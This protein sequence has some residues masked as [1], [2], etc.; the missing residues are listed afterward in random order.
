VVIALILLLILY[1]LQKSNTTRPLINEVSLVEQSEE[2]IKKPTSE[3]PKETTKITEVNSDSIAEVKTREVEDLNVTYL[4]AYREFE[5]F[6]KCSMVYN[7]MKNGVDLTSNYIQ[8]YVKPNET[9]IQY[10]QIYIDLCKSLLL[11][12]KENS[13][14]ART[15]LSKRIDDTTPV[16][17]EEVALSQALEIQD[18][19]TDV[20]MK[21]YNEKSGNNQLTEEQ[22]AANLS[23]TMALAKELMI[24]LNRS[25]SEL[26]DA[27]RLLILKLVNEQKEL[28]N[29]SNISYISYLL[30]FF[31][32]FV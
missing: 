8:S 13:I 32:T 7:G 10:Y 4:T 20:S 6:N 12:E 29:S 16:T 24:I 25:P 23:R 30:F 26:T 2:E 3:K 14:D 15:R 18:R 31:V 27:D 5:Q 21:I 22:I 11:S 9:Q 28:T 19:I 17:K 1:F